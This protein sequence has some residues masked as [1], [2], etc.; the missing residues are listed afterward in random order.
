MTGDLFV[1]STVEK[2][3][4]DLYPKKK[5]VV[6]SFID[7]LKLQVKVQGSKTGCKV[8]DSSDSRTLRCIVFPILHGTRSYRR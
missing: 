6:G 2:T 7:L 4:D 1:R 8:A 3:S 5:I